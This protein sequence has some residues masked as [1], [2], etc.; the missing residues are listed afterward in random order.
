MS[1]RGG[2]Y[3]HREEDWIELDAERLGECQRVGWINAN[4]LIVISYYSLGRHC[5]WGELG[6]VNK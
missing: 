2:G 1:D 4:I 5:H 6:Q 3:L